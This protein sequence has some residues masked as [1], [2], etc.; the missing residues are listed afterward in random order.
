LPLATDDFV[1]AHSSSAARITFLGGA[2]A[3]TTPVR[4]AIMRAATTRIAEGVR[5]ADPATAHEL[6]SVNAEE[7]RFD[8]ETPL[9]ADLEQG[10]ILIGEPSAAAPEGYLRR[11]VSVTET[12]GMVSVETTGVAIEELIED[13]SL[14]VSQQITPDDIVWDQV[15]ADGVTVE[16]GGAAMAGALEDG[17]RAQSTQATYNKLSLSFTET[18]VGGARLNGSLS[19]SPSYHFHVRAENFDLEEA[20][21]TTTI[22]QRAALTVEGPPLKQEIEIYEF[23]PMPIKAM[24]GPVPVWVTS[25]FTL[26]AGVDASGSVALR[27]GVEQGVAVTSG[28]QYRSGS[29]SPVYQFKPSFKVITPTASSNV[30]VEVYAGARAELK[31]YDL[32]GPYGEVKPLV[33]CTF[34]IGGDPWWRAKRAIDLTAGFV[35]EVDVGVGWL[36]W[37]WTIADVSKTWRVAEAPLGQS[38]PG[39]APPVNDPP[40]TPP[41]DDP[42]VTPPGDDP[43]SVVFFPDANLEREVREALRKPT[44]DITV[45]DMATLTRLEQLSAGI[46]DLTGLQH[47]V[48][49]SRLQLTASQVSDLSPLAGLTNLG[50]LNLHQNQVSDLSPLAGLTNLTWLGLSHNQISDLAPLAG[51][52]N[53]RQLYLDNNQISDLAP[54]AGLT[55]LWDLGLRHNQISDLAPLAGLTNL[56]GLHLLGNQISDLSPLAGLTNL[57]GLNLSEN[58]ISNLLPLAG[59]TNLGHLFLSTNYISDLSPLVANPGLG[60]GDLLHL[61]Y[62]L[63]DLT[64]GS[65]ARNDIA[66]LEGRGVQ[67][68]FWPQR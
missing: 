4:S 6:L 52:T 54:L 12:G 42:P 49:L 34:T 27:V 30:T 16:H 25:K 1:R 39:T 29:W 18:L 5:V 19:V 37:T 9:L 28:L 67:V 46:S 44:G 59:L 32:A 23:R 61:R 20:R 50:T 11:V 62:N 17:P 38:D 56:T 15:L 14:N 60:L 48:N 33:E 65:T 45:A 7:L 36:K 26:F 22:T 2:G 21:F 8:A 57:T 55:N 35:A 3:V 41:G 31:L 68:P 24:V 66:T 43:G 10:Q 53:L 47:A 58:Q 40:V 64:A 51:L 13:G 63:L